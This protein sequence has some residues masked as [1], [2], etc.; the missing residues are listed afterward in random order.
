MAL[1]YLTLMR[2]DKRLGARVVTGVCRCCSSSKQFVYLIRQPVLRP[3]CAQPRHA[4]AHR[5]ARAVIAALNQRECLVGWNAVQIQKSPSDKVSK[6]AMVL[7]LCS[8][9]VRELMARAVLL[10]DHMIQ[11]QA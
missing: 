10:I 3:H 5:C 1:A 7:E 6:A 8:K 11:R 2:Q 4:V 9:G